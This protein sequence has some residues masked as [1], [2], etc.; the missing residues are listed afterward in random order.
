MVTKNM[1]YIKGGMG[2]WANARNSLSFGLNLFA[3]D[4]LDE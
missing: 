1:V 3:V 2:S 4:A